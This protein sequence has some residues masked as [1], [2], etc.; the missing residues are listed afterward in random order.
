MKCIFVSNYINHH[1]I[2]FCNAMFKELNGE[3]LF[4]QT[5]PME[6]ERVKMGWQAEAIVPYVRYYEEEPEKC[7]SLIMDSQIVLFGGSDEE[8]YIQPRLKAGKPVLRYSE[9]LYKTGQWK[10]I[11]PRGLLKKYKDHTRYGSKSVYLLCAGA[12]VPSDFH[13]IRAYADKMF[14][15]GYFPEDKVYDVDKLIKK[16]GF[17]EKSGQSCVYLLWAGRFIDWKHPELPVK[18]ARWLKSKGCSFHL[19]MIGGGELEP[20]IREL[21]RDFDVGDCVTLTGYRKPEEVREAMEKADIY[22]VTSDRQEGWGV[23]VNEAMNSCCAVI[24]NHM[25]GAVPYLLSHGKNGMVYR[26]GD[27]QALFE[28]AERLCGDPGLRRKLGK[29][30]YDRIHE[31]WNPRNAARCLLSLCRERMGFEVPGMDLPENVISTDGP[32]S[33]APV[34]Q[35]RKMYE[36]MITNSNE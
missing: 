12:Y 9:R 29:A 10:A 2:P 30:A 17:G 3:F 28:Y 33:A 22:L 36:L 35:E 11:S 31:V 15:W 5:E 20:M 16:K 1:Q 32:C 21:I 26:D 27:E 24:G 19:D 25:A 8:S 14:R 6:E 18:T 13:L 23:V 4:I 34:I 7:R